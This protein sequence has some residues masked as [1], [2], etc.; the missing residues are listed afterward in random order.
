MKKIFIL[1]M[2]L[3]YMSFNIHEAY[4]A[5]R[6]VSRV[7]FETYGDGR[8]QKNNP[9]AANQD[10]FT[11][12]KVDT[13]REDTQG[14]GTVYKT[15]C[16]G[17]GGENCRFKNPGLI[18]PIKDSDGKEILSQSYIANR[19]NLIETDLSNTIYEESSSTNTKNYNDIVN[20]H[21]IYQT[22]N[23]DFD[24]NGILRITISFEVLT[25]E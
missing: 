18:E 11:Y 25:I 21:S 10:Q 9:P 1:S 15:Y 23:W 24:T 14:G 4:A 5:P 22:A 17:A 12:K 6:L 7:T 3:L 19:L 8:W 2:F 20:N 13:D 16:L